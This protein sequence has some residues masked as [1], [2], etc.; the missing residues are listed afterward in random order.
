MPAS[1]GRT[2]ATF[3]SDDGYDVVAADN[4]LTGRMANIEHLRNESRFE[5]AKVDVSEPFDCGGGGVRVSFR[6]S[7]ES[8]GLWRARNRDV[9]G[10]VVRDVQLA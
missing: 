9:E 10:W 4:L 5:F 3:C 2:C 8:R 6:Q 1:S 7:G